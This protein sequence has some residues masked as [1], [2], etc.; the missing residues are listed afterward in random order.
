[1]TEIHRCTNCVLPT[2]LPS[3]KLDDRGVCNLCRDRERHMER[4]TQ[5]R[6]AR[7]AKWNAIVAAAKRCRRRYDCVVPLSGGKDSTYVLYACSKQYGLKCLCVTF[8][9]GFL[10]D[11]A[12]ENISRALSACDAD[13]LTF[14]ASRETLLRLYRVFITRCGSFCAVCMR[15]IDESI[16]TAQ[17]TFDIP[18]IVTGGGR[19]VTYLSTLSELLQNG[20]VGFFS[21]VARGT[22][23]EDDAV[24]LGANWRQ[25]QRSPRLSQLLFRIKARLHLIR[26]G[27]PEGVG[28][29]DC[30]DVERSEVQKTIAAEMGWRRTG[31][32]FEH[33]D[34]ALHPLVGYTHTLRFP[35]LTPETA[36]H[37]GQIRFGEITREEALKREEELLV[38]R[39]TPVILDEFLREI[40]MSRQEF[41]RHAADWR[42]ALSFRT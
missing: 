8:D 18:F 40:G 2:S 36:H 26:T 19:R 11:Q 39:Q 33:T 10:T 30:L 27:C 24:K 4:W 25:A 21:R 1:M 20:E 38:D 5:D 37:S 12:R 9:N 6:E 14:R 16:R 17:R 29:Y 7:R 28:I 41:D 15:G 32:H 22:P 35:E 23:V 31:E 3:L 13:H 42:S 34:C